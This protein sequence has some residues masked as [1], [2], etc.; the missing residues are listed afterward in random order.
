MVL[1]AGPSLGHGVVSGFQGQSLSVSEVQET[2]L[3]GG[4]AARRLI[5]CAWTVAIQPCV[6]ACVG[7]G[8]MGWLRT[9]SRVVR[10]ARGHTKAE[11][12]VGVKISPRVRGMRARS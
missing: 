10:S 1:V 8:S 4:R 9:M 7:V 12:P 3:S 5:R 6:G 11:H 2:C